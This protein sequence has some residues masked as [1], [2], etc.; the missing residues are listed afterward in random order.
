MCPNITSITS[1][2]QTALWNPLITEYRAHRYV[3]KKVPRMVTKLTWT[4]LLWSWSLAAFSFEPVSFA[5]CPMCCRVL[6][7][8]E[9]TPCYDT[10]RHKNPKSI[11]EMYLYNAISHPVRALDNINDGSDKLIWSSTWQGMILQGRTT[12]HPSVHS[13]HIGPDSDHPTLKDHWIP[14]PNM[15]KSNN[16]RRISTD[17]ITR[18]YSNLLTE[19]IPFSSP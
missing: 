11:K 1:I 3:H 7:L 8:K 14:P 5:S 6:C 12:N 4:G 15:T 16:N 19:L 17:R 10:K 9:H 18:S 13:Y 2:R